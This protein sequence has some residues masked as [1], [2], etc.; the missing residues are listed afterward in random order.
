[1]AIFSAETSRNK[2]REPLSAQ[3]SASSSRPQ[4]AAILLRRHQEAV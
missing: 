4:L 2:A 3:K 1:L